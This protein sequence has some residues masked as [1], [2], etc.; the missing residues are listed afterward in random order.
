MKTSNSALSGCA[1][2]EINNVGAFEIKIRPSMSP[3]SLRPSFLKKTIPS[4]FMS[5]HVIFNGTI[6]QQK[7]VIQILNR[8]MKIFENNTLAQEVSH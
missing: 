1:Y 4:Y 6:G 8:N 7:E 5:Y 3:V 2:A